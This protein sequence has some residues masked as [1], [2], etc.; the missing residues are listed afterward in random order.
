MSSKRKGH[1]QEGNR[2]KERKTV[3]FGNVKEQPPRV[4][5]ED[6]PRARTDDDD[7]INVPEGEEAGFDEVEDFS[8][9]Y[10]LE[11]FN[12]YQEREEGK[13]T[14]SGS[15][16]DESY[17]KKRAKNNEKFLKGEKI[18][19]QTKRA[20]D[21]DDPDEDEDAAQ[22]DAWLDEYDEQVEAFAASGKK[23]PTAKVKRLDELEEEAKPFDQVALKT[24][25][26]EHL[27]TRETVTKALRRLGANKPKKP[28]KAK[29]DKTP[30]IKDEFDIVTELADSLLSA[31]YLNVY[32]DTKEQIE[33]SMDEPIPKPVQK[34]QPIVPEKPKVMW[35]YQVNEQVYGPYSNDEMLA[36]SLGG[37]FIENPV[38]VRKVDTEDIYAEEGKFVPISEVDFA[39]Y[40]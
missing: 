20:I 26:I 32:S 21:E 12:M 39:Q 8:G 29:G 19:K 4:E 34:V 18:K 37:Y 24:K 35:E 15:Y 9:G 3:S 16:Y 11:A 2:G 31:G 23:F 22:E 25:L 13:F 1:P 36:W 28:N 30:E 7:D 10:K 17:T 5:D 38:V 33:D 14:D 6:M 40:A 27:Q